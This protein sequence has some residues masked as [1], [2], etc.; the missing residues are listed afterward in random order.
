LL[1]RTSWNADTIL[2]VAT[3]LTQ[4]LNDEQQI[5]PMHSVLQKQAAKLGNVQI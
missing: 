2:V 1:Q 3:T 5:K 4:V